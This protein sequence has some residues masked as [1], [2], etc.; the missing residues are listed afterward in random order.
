MRVPVD[1]QYKSFT[2]RHI[3]STLP[4]YTLCQ[5]SPLSLWNADYDLH[6]EIGV[7]LYQVRL[8]SP[9]NLAHTTIATMPIPRSR[10]W[11]LLAGTIVL[12]IAII[13][14]ATVL[15][16]G[17]TAHDGS[18]DPGGTYKRDM[19]IKTT[20]PYSE[21][22]NSS[23]DHSKPFIA[24]AYL[25]LLSFLFSFIG[26]VASD[27]FC[28]NLST[29]A[30]YLGLSETTAGVTFLAF[31]NGSP[32]VFS[33]FSAMNQGTFSLAIGELIGAAT[34]SKSAILS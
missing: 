21:W 13:R 24:F 1:L 25:L 26:I 34:F 6:D 32:D 10:T 12:Q 22:Y 23:S 17:L 9:I 16:R 28:P 15:K 29:I 4:H 27:F 18:Y 7:P 11:L 19:T 5:Y 31:G 14:S 20:L 33:T 8:L 3:H 2:W 30:T